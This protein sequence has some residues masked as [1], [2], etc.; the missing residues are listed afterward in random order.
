M[1]KNDEL[2]RQIAGEYVKRYGE[3]LTEEQKKLEQENIVYPSSRMEQRI[4]KAT[5][6]KKYVRYLSAVAG[7]AACI[8][9]ILAIRFV[10]HASRSDTDAMLH[11]TPSHGAPMQDTPSQEASTQ[12]APAPSD[13]QDFDVIPLSFVPSD[14][15]TQKGFVQDR[16]KSVYSFEDR[17]GDDV[18]MTLEHAANVPNSESMAKL[19]IGGTI[20]YGEAA[21]GYYLLAFVSDGIL[22]ELSCR[23]DINTLTRFAGAII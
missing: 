12:K 3:L 6:Q 9:L 23:H 18:V 1:N 4:R 20:M 14:G 16:E 5:A 15:F 2:L 8:A 17:L 11:S 21:E 22:H 19:S 7:L 10:P 13:V